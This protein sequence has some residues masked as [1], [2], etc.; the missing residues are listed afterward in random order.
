MGRTVSTI[1]GPAMAKI[2]LVED[3]LNSQN[4]VRAILRS[5]DHEVLV[6]ENGAEAL[7]ILQGAGIDAVVTDLKMPVLNGLRLIKELRGSGDSIPIIAISGL[8]ADQLMLAEDYGAN[9]GLTKPVDRKKLLDVLNQILEDTR[10]DWS[11]AWI[12]PEF[13]K[14]GDH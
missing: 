11:N 10:S 8:N 7:E 1:P 6:A 2:L 3:D 12:H 5:G 4:L 14:V 13:G 9:A